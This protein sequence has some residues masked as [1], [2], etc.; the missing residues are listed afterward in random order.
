MLDL[1][2]QGSSPGSSLPFLLLWL[3]GMML[4]LYFLYIRPQQKRQKSME[5]MLSS[6][7]KGDR[8]LT[9][10]GMYGTVIGVKGD[11]AVLKVGDDTKVE[12][13]RSAIVD[14]VEKSGD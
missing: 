7:K 4:I 13:R 3:G 12:F 10:G 9:A 11:I 5:A 8:V 14:V 6:L 2:A 1:L